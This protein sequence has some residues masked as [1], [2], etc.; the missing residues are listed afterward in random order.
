MS[1]DQS[2]GE[3]E[4]KSVVKRKYAS[5]FDDTR[6]VTRRFGV[7]VKEAIMDHTRAGNPIAVWRDGGVVIVQPEDIVWRGRRREP[8]TF[9][10]EDEN[11]ESN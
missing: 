2:T 5:V 3:T 4:P 1:T 10:D 8:I 6:E 7:A 11:P 9:R